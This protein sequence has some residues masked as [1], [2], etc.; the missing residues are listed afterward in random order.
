MT[1]LRHA[2][3]TD[4]DA[5]EIF[6]RIRLIEPDAERSYCAASL[7]DDLWSLYVEMESA[8]TDAGTGGD[9]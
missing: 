9:E 1:D 3:L 8:P 4:Y 6:L 5:N 7:L 2:A